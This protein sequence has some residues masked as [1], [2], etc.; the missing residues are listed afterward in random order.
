MSRTP[1]AW[2]RTGTIL[3]FV[4]GRTKADRGDIFQGRTGF[5]RM[6]LREIVLQFRTADLDTG[7]SRFAHADARDEIRMLR[8]QVEAQGMLCPEKGQK[9]DER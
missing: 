6:A 7:V 4:P 2:R 3:A 5:Q 1:E 9:I 8:R